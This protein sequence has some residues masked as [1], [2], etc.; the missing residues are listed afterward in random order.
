MK[1]PNNYILDTNVPKTANL[2]VVGAGVTLENYNCVMSCISLLEKITSTK[3]KGLVLDALDEIF[4]E[5]RGQ[6]N[7][8]GAPGQGDAFM[9]WLHDNRWNFPEE[10]RVN[11]TKHNDTYVEFPEHQG[12]E[13]FDISDRKF[14]AVSNAH[15]NKPCIYQA[16]DSK[17]WGWKNALAEVGIEVHFMDENY[18]QAIYQRK[19]GNANE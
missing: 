9:K 5:Y 4:N 14:V 19:M 3:D 10:D 17:W 6:L 2:A 15:P 12:L 7:L 1:I 16:V 8:G 11:I 13:N 18:I